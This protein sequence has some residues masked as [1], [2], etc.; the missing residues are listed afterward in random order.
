LSFSGEKLSQQLRYSTSSRLFLQPWSVSGTF[1]PYRSGVKTKPRGDVSIFI[2]ATDCNNAILLPQWTILISL[3]R[4]RLRRSHWSYWQPADRICSSL[5][6]ISVWR[7]GRRYT[8]QYTRRTILA[9]QS[10]GTRRPT[11]DLNWRVI[12]YMAI[13]N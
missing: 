6:W 2:P 13:D 8:L 4:S 10:D 11:T 3:Q 1:G 12:Y 5:V 7:I 9:K